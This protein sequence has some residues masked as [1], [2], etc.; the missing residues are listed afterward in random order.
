MFEVFVETVKRF[1]GNAGSGG[2]FV[3]TLLV[4][5]TVMLV[6]S[7]ILGPLRQLLSEYALVFRCLGVAG[8]GVLFV[9][10]FRKIREMRRR[11]VSR[12]RFQRR[13]WA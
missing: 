1:A 5:F 6:G 11:S 4:L 12:R 9:A 10:G 2:L 8:A 7:A 3:L 13:S